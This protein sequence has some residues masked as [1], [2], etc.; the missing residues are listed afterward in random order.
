MKSEMITTAVLAFFENRGKDPM[1]DDK[2]LFETGIIDSMD[3]LEL[4]AELEERFK[5]DLDPEDM[6]VD[7]FRSVSRIVE[8]VSRSDGD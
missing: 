7:N 8:T 5:L 1:P 2:D 3:L 4:I 6:T